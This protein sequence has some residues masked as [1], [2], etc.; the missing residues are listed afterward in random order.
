[1]LNFAKVSYTPDFITYDDEGNVAHVFDVKNSFGIYGI[2][3]SNRL[4]FKLFTR[5]TGYPVEAVVVNKNSFRTK[6]MGATSHV[7]EFKHT[8][9]NYPSILKQMQAERESW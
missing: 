4:R 9:V 6:L 8:D 7:K 5:A 3:A 1:M 2:D